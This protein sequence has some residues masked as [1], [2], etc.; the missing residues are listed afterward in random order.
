MTWESSVSAVSK[1][2][3]P[4]RTIRC[5]LAVRVQRAVVGGDARGGGE[6]RD[7]AAQLVDHRRRERGAALRV[8]LGPK[9]AFSQRNMYFR[10]E[11]CTLAGSVVL[12]ARLRD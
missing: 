12:N 11:Q 1:R 4:N 9:H 2:L 6:L 3:C 5:D 8:R 10:N 7:R